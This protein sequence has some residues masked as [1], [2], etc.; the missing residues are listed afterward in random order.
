MKDLSG[1]ELEISAM[2][3]HWTYK[4]LGI[5][6]FRPEGPRRVTGRL[7]A[8]SK[9]EFLVRYDLPESSEVGDE[10]PAW[11]PF[12]NVKH[13]SALKTFC[14]LPNVQRQLGGNFYVSDD[15]VEEGE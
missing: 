9:Y 15:E 8:K 5:E 10:N 2:Q 11:Q 6:A 7:R 13:L 14:S 4:V 1:E 12:A 3:D